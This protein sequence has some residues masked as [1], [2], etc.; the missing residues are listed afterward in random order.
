MNFL[1]IPGME[2]PVSSVIFGTASRAMISGEDV[3]NLL[4]EALDVGV[5]TFDTA[6]E[7]QQAENTLGRWIKASGHRNSINVITKGGHEGQDRTK[8][9]TRDC[10]AADLEASLEAL[11]V[12]YIDVY[13]LHRDDPDV[14]VGLII[15]WMNELCSK[16]QI[17]AFGGSNWTHQ[18]ISAANEYAL[19]HGLQ[20]MVVSSPHF[21]L[22]EQVDDPWGGCLSIT[23][24][25]QCGARS[26]YEVQK[27]PLLAYSSLG[28][29]L[30]SGRVSSDKPEQAE[31]VLDIYAQ[32]GYCSTDNFERLRR[33]EILA[34][35]KKCTVA[36][37][38]LAWLLHSSI[39]TAAICTMSSGTRVRENAAAVD[40]SLN[41]SEWHYL[42]L[43]NA[44]M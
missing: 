1:T 32:K 4:D 14:P 33:V 15:E 12:D 31:R 5:N 44:S 42:N 40:I 30:F 35:S 43:E 16:G 20:P 21:G 28:R 26:W 11:R 9:I 29:G 10:I 7:Y 6:R 22:A 23:G 25:E 27:I 34:Q 36:Q 24:D 17:K 38:A 37:L 8:R 39:Q 3:S 2:N 19:E 18:R 41:K 13:L